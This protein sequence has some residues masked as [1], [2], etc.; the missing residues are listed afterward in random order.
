MER[1]FEEFKKMAEEFG[2][3]DEKTKLFRDRCTDMGFS[4]V[5]GYGLSE[6]EIIDALKNVDLG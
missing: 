6:E 2:V 3:S 4:M 5:L 1:T